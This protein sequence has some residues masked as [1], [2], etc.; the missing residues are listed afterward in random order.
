[1]CVCAEIHLFVCV[2]EERRLADDEK[3]LLVQLNW[4]KDDR[5][6]RF[7]LRRVDLTGV[8]GVPNSQTNSFCNPLYYFLVLLH[9]P[10]TTVSQDMQTR[11]PVQLAFAKFLYRIKGNF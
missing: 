5:E 11:F 6:G 1:M 8:R 10:R 3:P 4:N 7:L 2:A 9:N